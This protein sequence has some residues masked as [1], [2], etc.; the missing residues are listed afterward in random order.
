[1]G[2][3]EEVGLVIENLMTKLGKGFDEEEF[4]DL[5]EGTPAFDFFLF[6]NP[7]EIW[8]FHDQEAASVE[9]VVKELW[10]QVKG[11]VLKRGFVNR[12][13]LAVTGWKRRWLTLT[14]GAIDVHA[15]ETAADLAYASSIENNNN[16][17]DVKTIRI[18]LSPNSSVESLPTTHSRLGTFAAAHAFCLKDV[19]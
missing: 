10:L 5:T 19:V 15:S 2:D 17:K 1:M 18:Q 11:D 9:A 4:E 6:L 13:G 8:Y 7:L 12:R 3:K 14:P 16:N